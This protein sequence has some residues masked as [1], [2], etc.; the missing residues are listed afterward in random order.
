MSGQITFKSDICNIWKELGLGLLTTNC[1]L[2]NV[3][4]IENYIFLENM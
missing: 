4:V 1:I 2:F 3:K